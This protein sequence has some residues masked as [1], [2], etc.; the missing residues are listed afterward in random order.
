MLLNSR[1]G[2]KEI[3][4]AIYKALNIH[5]SKDMSFDD[6][7]AESNYFD[8]SPIIKRNVQVNNRIGGRSSGILDTSHSQ[9]SSRSFIHDLNS[10]KNI[11]SECSE[12][13]N[14]QEMLLCQVCKKVFE[15][16]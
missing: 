6:L 13:Y 9:I 4:N 14:E 5:I 2:N 7:Q 3:V 8:E 16:D 1:L 12:D 11:P 10:H 15:E